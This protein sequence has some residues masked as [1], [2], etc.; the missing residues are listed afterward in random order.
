MKGRRPAAVW[1]LRLALQAEWKTVAA[2]LL[3]WILAWVVALAIFQISP[4]RFYS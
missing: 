2:F 3:G 4:E 1:K